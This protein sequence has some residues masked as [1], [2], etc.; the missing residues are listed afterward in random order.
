MSKYL[1]KNVQILI[2]YYS[3]VNNYLADKIILNDCLPDY[4][5]TRLYIMNSVY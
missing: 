4:F 2:L 5:Q 1:L 3:L